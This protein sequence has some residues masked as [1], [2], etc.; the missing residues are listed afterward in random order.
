M[1]SANEPPSNAG[2]PRN[3]SPQISITPSVGGVPRDDLVL[4]QL[5]ERVRCDA[6][7]LEAPVAQGVAA[8]PAYGLG[9]GRRGRGDE[10]P[11][12]GKRGER[13]GEPAVGHLRSRGDALGSP[14]HTQPA[15]VRVTPMA[16]RSPAMVPP[17]GLEWSQAHD[18]QD[19]GRFSN[20]NR[21]SVS[22]ASGT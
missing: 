6:R 19:S 15:W 11:E 12:D 8:H 2:T 5:V 7:R 13:N 4:G 14:H 1:S 10:R 16:P 22:F 9:E 18:P 20:G 21:G 3:V 17:G